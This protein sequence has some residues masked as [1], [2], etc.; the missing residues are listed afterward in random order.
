M[1]L[2]I[3]VPPW[4][5]CLNQSLTLTVDLTD[6]QVGGLPERAPDSAEPSTLGQRGMLLDCFGVFDEANTFSGW[7]LA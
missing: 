1:K 4:Q 6:S 5:L 3:S 2:V 7:E